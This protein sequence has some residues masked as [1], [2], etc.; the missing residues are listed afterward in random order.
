MANVILFCVPPVVCCTAVVIVIA[1]EDESARHGPGSSL[2]R[3]SSAD[4]A[5][6]REEIAALLK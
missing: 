6:L 1:Q 5:Q 2:L 4:I 3:L